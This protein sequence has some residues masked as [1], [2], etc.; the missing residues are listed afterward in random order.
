ML[1]LSLLKVLLS[2]LEP[3]SFDIILFI[4]SN[5]MHIPI[6]SIQSNSVCSTNVKSTVTFADG[7]CFCPSNK[8]EI[9]SG[10]ELPEIKKSKKK[11]K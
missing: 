6:I 5:G 7:Y 3:F 2:L 4:L 9:P 11:I 1:I 10:S 8:I